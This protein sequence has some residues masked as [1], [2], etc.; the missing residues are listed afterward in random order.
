MT[1]LLIEAWESV[2]AAGLL[3]LKVL[4][5]LLHRADHI[6]VVF[7]DDHLLFW[8]IHSHP[9]D[10]IGCPSDWHP[11][12][13]ILINI[14]KSSTPTISQTRT[15]NPL[16]RPLAPNSLISLEIKITRRLIT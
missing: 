16:L 4:L 10:Q 9:T 1:D 6:L 11:P 14:E 13:L 8:G 2:I 5:V 15:Y 7:R 12:S 3:V